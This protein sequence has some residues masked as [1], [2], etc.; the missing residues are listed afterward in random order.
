MRIIKSVRPILLA[1]ALLLVSADFVAARAVRAWSYQ[2]LLAQSDLAVIATPTTCTNTEEQIN[3]PGF[4]GQRV[5]GVNT[6]FSVSGVLKGDK[7]LKDFVFHHYRP[8]P[9][10]VI[11]DNGPTFVYLAVAEKPSSP[12]RTYVL[13]LRQEVDGRYAPVVGQT[14]PGIAVR[15]VEGVYE[16]AVTETQTK[17]GIEIANVLKECQTIKPGMTRAD[18]SRVFSTEGGLSTVT[19]RTYVHRDCPY[20]KVEV[21]FAPS[22][23]KPDAEKPADVITKISKPYLEWSISD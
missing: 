20:I 15:E 14:D 18:L 3:L 19:H 12:K 4:V 16:T 6:T 17:L 21:D 23:P 5:T 2:E 22:G 11:V 9:D 1:I 13:F 7:A 10:G 8:A